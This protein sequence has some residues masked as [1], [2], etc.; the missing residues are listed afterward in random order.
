MRSSSV[1]SQIG[2]R[3]DC[4]TRRRSR[5]V[6]PRLEISAAMPANVNAAMVAA[7]KLQNVAGRIGTDKRAKGIEGTIAWAGS[8]DA[9]ATSLA[10]VV[11]GAALGGEL[12]AAGG[13]G[14]RVATAAAPFHIVLALLA[15]VLAALTGGLLGTAC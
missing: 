2:P 9:C 3:V 7:I 12:V 15:G 11:A 14:H 10:T 1:V 5:R 4:A 13:S 6:R 8:A